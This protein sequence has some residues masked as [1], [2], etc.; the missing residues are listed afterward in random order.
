M[1]FLEIEDVIALLGAEIVRAGS[2]SAWCRKNG[3]DRATLN[4]TLNGH[5]PPTKEMIEALNLRA[6]FISGDKSK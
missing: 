2:Q 3:I 6:V 4:K 5:R 1:R